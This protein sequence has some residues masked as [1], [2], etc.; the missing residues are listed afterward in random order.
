MLLDPHPIL[1][2]KTCAMLVQG[3][4]VLCG[5]ICGAASPQR[6]RRRGSLCGQPVPLPQV[7]QQRRQVQRVL[8]QEPRRALHRQ[9]AVALREG[10]DLEDEN[11]LPGECMLP[12]SAAVP[13]PSTTDVGCETAAFP[14]LASFACRL[15][16]PSVVPGAVARRRAC[17]GRRR[18]TSSTCWRGAGTPASPRSWAST[19]SAAPPRGC[20]SMRPPHQFGSTPFGLPSRHSLRKKRLHARWGCHP[21][22]S[23]RPINT[24]RL[25]NG[26]RSRDVQVTQKNMGTGGD[27]AKG[28]GRDGIMDLLVMENIFYGR[29]T[30]RIYDLKVTTC[31]YFWLNAV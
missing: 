29:A 8:R 25:R 11:P 15:W 10:K 18:R 7:G 5:A 14:P 30:S 24:H 13:T 28:A 12:P 20:S 26:R 23:G 22:T 17:W 6:G 27:G 1:D 16:I 31:Q 2:H 4:G 19:R 3:G 9:A 21:H